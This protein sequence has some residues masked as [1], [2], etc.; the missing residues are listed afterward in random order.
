MAITFRFYTDPALT[1]PLD[2]PLYL[3]MSSAAGASG[4]GVLYLGSTVPG[5]V[6]Q[7]TAEPGVAVVSV[8]IDG[9]A[10]GLP[11]NAVRLASS[12]AGLDSAVPGASLDLG[13]EIASQIAV[14]IHFRVTQDGFTPGDFANLAL[15]INALSEFAI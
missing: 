7:A 8:S 5:R 9:G 4:D 10:G 11:V 12:A 15:Q 13:V 1:T 3:F 14:A 6:L 2:R